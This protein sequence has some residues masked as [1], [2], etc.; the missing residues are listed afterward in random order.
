MHS[1]VRARD[2]GR[3]RKSSSKTAWLK[4][5]GRVRTVRA[6]SGPALRHSVGAACLFPRPGGQGQHQLLGPPGQRWT[7][8]LAQ[9]PLGRMDALGP[10]G[11]AKTTSLDT[12]ASGLDDRAPSEALCLVGLFQEDLT[13]N[14]PHWGISLNGQAQCF[15]GSKGRVYLTFCH[16]LVEGAYLEVAVRAPRITKSS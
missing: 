2:S 15:Q 12:W 16:T 1:S 14:D 13:Q 5:A 10:P 4:P 6:G 9:N 7:P 3:P 11:A 8:G